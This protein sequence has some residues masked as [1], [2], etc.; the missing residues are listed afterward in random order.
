MMF[1]SKRK[2]NSCHGNAP[3]INS[4]SGNDL[5][6][7]RCVLTKSRNTEFPLA[8]NAHLRKNIKCRIV[9]TLIGY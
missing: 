4:K 6:Y 2:R 9:P 1:F 3:H 5:D 7:C 8:V